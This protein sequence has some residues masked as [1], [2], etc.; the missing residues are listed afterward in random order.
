MRRS[1]HQLTK[2]SIIHPLP[3]LVDADDS[4]EGEISID[5][6]MDIEEDRS[7]LASYYECLLL[8]LTSPRFSAGGKDVCDYCE[9]DE[10]IP[11]LDKLRDTA[12]RIARHQRT[13]IHTKRFHWLRKSTQFE[14]D[15]RNKLICPYGCGLSF[16]EYVI[17]LCSY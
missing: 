1:G 10:T 5:D 13:M 6:E 8:L 2:T 3:R 15:E 16:K 9:E 14:R 4:V 11:V 17:P 7:S 12:S